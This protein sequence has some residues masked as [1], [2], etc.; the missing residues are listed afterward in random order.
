MTN[1]PAGIILLTCEYTPFP[2]GIARYSEHLAKEVRRIGLEALVIAP[3]YSE[4]PTPVDEQYTYRVLGHHQ[5]TP[6]AALSVLTIL[7]HAPANRLFLAA[8]IRSVLLAY[9]FRFFHRRPY[10][11]MIHGSEVSKFRSANPLRRYVS[12]AYKTAE[13]ITANSQAT[14][15]IFSAAFGK[16]PNSVVNYLGVEP[17]WFT[18]A[19]GQFD[20]GELA[21]IPSDA[22]IICTVG[23][24]EP[25]KG[26]L[27]AVSAIARARDVYGLRN[28]LFVIAGRPEDEDYTIRV[29][30]EARRL[31]VRT[32]QTGAVSED[33]LK[34]LYSRAVCHFMCARV[35]PGK[36]EGF[37]LVIIEAGAQKCPTIATAVGGIAEA[38]GDAGIITEINDFDGMAQALASYAS[39]PEKR[40]HD[41]AAAR[42]KALTFS[43]RM[44]ARGTFPELSWPDGTG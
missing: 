28:P 27:E 40:A 5:V 17:G 31:D 25:R 16:H 14:L 11:A 9:T 30:A 19:A 22:A 8:D 36:V 32:I 23:R 18:Q 24:I 21:R 44:C 41:G 7:R 13:M 20:N 10:R 29:L 37:G 33:D 6:A 15:D 42:R 34:R 1:A 4:F 12:R 26:Q 38:M 35:L 3:K 2:G 43:W 39:D